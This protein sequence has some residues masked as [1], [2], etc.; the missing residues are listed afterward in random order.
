MLFQDAATYLFFFFFEHVANYS[1][2][3]DKNQTKQ[4]AYLSFPCPL[5]LSTEAAL[6][7]R[8]FLFPSL[9]LPSF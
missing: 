4:V 3:K 2:C 5:F 8:F 6:K 7:A 9:L 1:N